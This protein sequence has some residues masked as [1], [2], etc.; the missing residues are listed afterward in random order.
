MVDPI[1]SKLCTQ[2]LVL[3]TQTLDETSRTLSYPNETIL[4]SNYISIAISE[5]SR[6]P[7]FQNIMPMKL[8]KHKED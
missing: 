8:R 5:Q 4:Y 7:Y 1:Q 2:E 6:I 3:A